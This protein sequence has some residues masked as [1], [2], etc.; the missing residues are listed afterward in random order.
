VHGAG[1]LPG[2]RVDQH[3]LQAAGLGV[4]PNG[5][6]ERGTA[7]PRPRESTSKRIHV[8][9]KAQEYGNG[10]DDRHQRQKDEG[11]QR[12]QSDG[13]IFSIIP[14]GT[15]PQHTEIPPSEQTAIS[16]IALIV[17]TQAR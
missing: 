16:R 7:H 5:D 10:A 2:R 15:T 17:G 9:G 1:V 6:R 12:A 11:K 4:R 3:R 8:Q 13:R 14:H